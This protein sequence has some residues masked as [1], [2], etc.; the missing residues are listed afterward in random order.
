MKIIQSIIQMEIAG[1]NYCSRESS[2]SVE[3]A[4]KVQTIRRGRGA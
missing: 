2:A 4:E 1:V 3:P